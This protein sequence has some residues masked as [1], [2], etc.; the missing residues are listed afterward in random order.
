M[1]PHRTQDLAPPLPCTSP[2]LEQHSLPL[3]SLHFVHLPCTRNNHVVRSSL[4]HP[5]PSTSSSLS[6]CTYQAPPSCSCF[7]VSTICERPEK[8]AGMH[9]KRVFDVVPPVLCRLASIAKACH[10]TLFFD[11]ARHP[12][13]SHLLIGLSHPSAGGKFAAAVQGIARRSRPSFFLFFQFVFLLDCLCR[14]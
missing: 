7:Y 6:P 9:G 1:I 10:E 3:T 8:H 5:T 12:V 11:H 13:S 4:A 14:C 2:R